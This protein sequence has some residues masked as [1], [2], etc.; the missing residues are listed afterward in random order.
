MQNL[1]YPR[2]IFIKLR[3]KVYL[4]S[5]LHLK[6]LKTHNSM[7]SI[8]SFFPEDPPVAII[9]NGPVQRQY[10]RPGSIVWPL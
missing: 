1:F 6:I 7:F 4:I 8:E 2:R 3:D 5:I 9:Y 10:F